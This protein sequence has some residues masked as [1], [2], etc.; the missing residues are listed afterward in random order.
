MEEK[1]VTVVLFV[2]VLTMFQSC[3][4]DLIS[5][6]AERRITCQHIVSGESRTH[7]PNIVPTPKTQH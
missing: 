5:S 4:Y 1:Q 3:R 2:L 7:N 6:N